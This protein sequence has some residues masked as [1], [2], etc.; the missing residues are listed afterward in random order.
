MPGRSPIWAV[1][2]FF[3]GFEGGEPEIPK[4]QAEPIR[5]QSRPAEARSEAP[6]RA[7]ELAEG[8]S[9]RAGLTIEVIPTIPTCPALPCLALPCPT[10][11]C[12]APPFPELTYSLLIQLYF[13]LLITYL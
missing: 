9:E 4:I 8:S 11:P 10:L 6:V 13:S 5:G 12:P 3:N 7:S 1:S 2:F